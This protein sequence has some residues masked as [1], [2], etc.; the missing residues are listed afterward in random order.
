MMFCMTI[1]KS[2]ARTLEDLIFA[3]KI[4]KHVK[5]NAIVLVKNKQT[6]GIGAGQMSR[7][8]STNIAINKKLLNFNK[9]QFVAA[10][11]AFFPFTD[12][13]IKLTKNNC[14]AI[15]QPSGSINDKKMIECAN[16]K[17][18]PLYFTKFR[19]FKH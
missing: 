19:L 10:S 1:K 12:N 15:V 3:L 17:K 14:I 6:L 13:I 2:N 5:S 7:I 8:D 16:R 11:D 4:T 18:I 9:I